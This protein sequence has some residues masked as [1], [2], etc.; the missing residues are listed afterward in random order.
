MFI[1][2]STVEPRVSAHLSYQG[3]GMQICYSSIKI[4]HAY[5]GGIRVSGHLE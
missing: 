5:R 4:N 3:S 1:I 2:Y